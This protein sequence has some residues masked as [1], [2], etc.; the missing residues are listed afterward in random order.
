MR[1][2]YGVIQ[3]LNT[4]IVVISFGT[5]YWAQVWLEET[6]V[7]FPLLLDPQHVAY[8]VYGLERSLSRSWGLKTMGRY[9]RLLTSGRRWRG[10]KG[11]SSQLGGDFIVDTQGIVRLAYR[12][13]DPTDRPPVEMLLEQLRPLEKQA[14]AG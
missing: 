8:Q 2:Q 10:I 13:H 7:P 14:V 3:S 1:S 12:S 9:A 5:E 11:D 4:D 6:D